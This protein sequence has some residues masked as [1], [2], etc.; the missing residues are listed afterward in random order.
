MNRFYLCIG[1]TSLVALLVYFGAIQENTDKPLD[2]SIQVFEPQSPSSETESDSIPEASA[3]FLTQNEDTQ[4]DENENSPFESTDNTQVVYEDSANLINE[5]TPEANTPFES[6]E[7]ASEENIQGETEA[8]RAERAER[9]EKLKSTAPAEQV[10]IILTPLSRTI[11]SS[12]ISTPILSSQV[13]APVTKIYKRMG[14]SFKKGD[15]LIEVDRTVF[16]ANLKKSKAILLR[17]YTVLGARQ[18]LY[19]DSISSL[20]ELRDAQAAVAIAKA[21]LALAQNQ[22]DWALIKAPYDGKVVAVLVEE[23]ELPQPGQALVEVI[24]DQKIIARALAPAALFQKLS[25]G[26]IIHV[27]IPAIDKTVDAKIIRIGAVIEP[28]SETIAFDA[29][30]DNSE[31]LLLPGMTGFTK[32]E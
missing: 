15:P 5:N 25:I 11:L 27:H 10:R 12:Q 4:T 6:D 2:L 32:I 30:I 8:E 20:T 7:N 13:S 14:E 21:E 22:Y 3:E 31:H 1:I 23:F 9:R 24:E 19:D 16:S 28:S 18:K 17:A 26:K 29:E